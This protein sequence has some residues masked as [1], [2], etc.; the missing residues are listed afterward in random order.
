LSHADLLEYFERKL[1]DDSLTDAISLLKK[2]GFIAIE[3]T[4]GSGA[5][6][7]KTSPHF[8]GYLQSGNAQFLETM[9]INY[10]HEFLNLCS[11]W[12]TQTNEEHFYGEN[13]FNPIKLLMDYNDNEI[14]ERIQFCYDEIESQLACLYL[15]GGYL[16]D[17]H[18]VP[19]RRLVNV[20]CES[21]IERQIR[22]KRWSVESHELFQGPIVDANV[23]KD[24][25]VLSAS[26]DR[27]FLVDCLP[28]EL[29]IPQ[30]LAHYRSPFFQ[31]FEP[32]TILKKELL[33][34]EHF[35]SSLKVYSGAL[36][37][38]AYHEFQKSLAEHG[39]S[40]NFS[41][42]LSG[43]PG[44][45]KTEL[46]RQMA[47][48]SDRT[49]LVVNLSSLREKFFGESEKNVRRLFD[50][51]ELIKSSLEHEPIVLFN[52]ADGFFQHRNKE[53]SKTGQTETAI[54]TMFLN[55]LENYSGI[56]MAT[57][58]F[59]HGFDPAFERRWM[60]KLR[61]P[62]P[63][64]QLRRQLISSKFKNYLEAEQ[65]G[66]LAEKYVFAPGQLEN[67]L[68]AFLLRNSVGEKSESIEQLLASEIRGW[69]EQKPEIGFGRVVQ[70]DR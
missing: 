2:R 19:I 62:Q 1:L 56:L 58:N 30:S 5:V 64:V 34:N 22:L 11:T 3:I 7:Y 70:N 40:Q 17:V 13:L 32:S 33:Y 6:E 39:L 55:E 4:M 47:R 65:I 51:I 18:S 25:I 63:D 31:V 26:F 29:Q 46:A 67:A 14:F 43:L 16:N 42:M 61:V 57:T 23:N 9:Q 8:A 60:V 20:I 12:F 24:D 68:K 45:G 28:Q 37:H 49:L 15:L 54:I 59:T 44:T 69:G 48:E 50:E 10:K 35:Q 41:I 21:P 52:E 53:S 66:Y 27:T 36:T 38:A